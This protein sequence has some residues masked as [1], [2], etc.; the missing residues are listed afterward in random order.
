MP[1]QAVEV[2]LRNR[3]DSALVAQYARDWWQNQSFLGVLDRDRKS[4]LDTVF[5]RLRNR[6]L[7]ITTGQVVASLSF[8]FWVGLL[9]A[10]YNPPIWGGRLHTAFPFLPA[11]ESRDSLARKAREVAY[12]RNRISHHEPLIGQNISIDYS[13]VK[14]LIEWV[15]QT[16]WAWIQPHCRVPEIM[17]DKP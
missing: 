1:I 4:D 2:G 8:G 3:I 15:C 13:N 7:P 9:Q 11:R 10:R 16:K 17:R 6:K 5:R 12:L 14:T